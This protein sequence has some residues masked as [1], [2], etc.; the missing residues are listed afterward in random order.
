MDNL[1]NIRNILKNKDIYMFERYNQTKLFK[2][3]LQ[4]T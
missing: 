3:L 2:S 4:I 1:D